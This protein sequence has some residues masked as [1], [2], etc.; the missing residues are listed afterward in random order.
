MLRLGRSMRL[1]ICRNIMVWLLVLAAILTGSAWGQEARLTDIVVTNNRDDLLTYLNVEG[2]FTEKITK[3]IMS[4]APATF[5]FF[6]S[7]YQVRNM[8]LDKKVV[9]HKLTHTIKYNPLKKE[10]TIRRSWDSGGP[11]ITPDMNEARQ[12]MASITSLK[13]VPLKTLEKGKLYQLRAKAE[14]SRL[15]LPFYLHYVLFFASLWDFETDWY[16]IDFNF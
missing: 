11:L 10:F 2:A 1:R 4:G 3:A 7:L 14:L 15:T 9:S 5:S 16:T 13:I 6:I 8:W 12:L